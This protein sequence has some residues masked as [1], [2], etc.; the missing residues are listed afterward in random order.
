MSGY[1]NASDFL[2]IYGT[3][4]M[5]RRAFLTSSVIKAGF[6]ALISLKAT[7]NNGTVMHSSTNFYVTRS[8][9]VVNVV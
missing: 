6:S 2:D 9:I 4:A 3:V 5:V 8:A 1:K 7:L